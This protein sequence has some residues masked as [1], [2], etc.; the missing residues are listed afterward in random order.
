M[1]YSFVTRNVVTFSVCLCLPGVTLNFL[2]F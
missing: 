2:Y 1:K